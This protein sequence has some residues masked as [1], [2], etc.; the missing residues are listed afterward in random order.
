[1]NAPKGKESR[2]WM[3]IDYW[4]PSKIFSRPSHGSCRGHVD[5]DRFAH[6]QKQRARIFH[7]PIHIRYCE[8]KCRGPM[9]QSHLNFGRDRYFMIRSVD[10]ENAVDLH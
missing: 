1:M 4:L 2:R 7:P 8:V 10:V 3:D 9:I 6:S 5:I